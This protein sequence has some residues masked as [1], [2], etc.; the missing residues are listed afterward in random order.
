LAG[1]HL[2]T[3]EVT[4]VIRE[5]GLILTPDIPVSEFGGPR[6]QTVMLKRPDGSMLTVEAEF[7]IPFSHPLP[8]AGKPHNSGYV[9]MLKGIEKQE[10]PVGTEIWT[11][12]TD[13]TTEEQRDVGK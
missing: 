9:C 4:F 12:T 3:V 11:V 10:V 7:N 6:V 1:K 13:V 5:R 8:L 2:L